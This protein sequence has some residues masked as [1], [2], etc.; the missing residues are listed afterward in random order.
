MDGVEC[1]EVM[2][3]V[4]AGCDHH[5]DV[6]GRVEGAKRKRASDVHLDELRPQRRAHL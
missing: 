4:A 2:R 5:V 1:R 6:T 3:D